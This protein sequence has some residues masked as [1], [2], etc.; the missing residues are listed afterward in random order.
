M[1]MAEHGKPKYRLA[2]MMHRIEKDYEIVDKRHYCD[3]GAT[4]VVFRPKLCGPP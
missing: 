2:M 4:V 1:F 3:S